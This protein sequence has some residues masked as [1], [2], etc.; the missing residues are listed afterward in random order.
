MLVETLPRVRPQE[1]ETAINTVQNMT[2]LKPSE[3]GI[4]WIKICLMEKVFFCYAN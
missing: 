2:E 1:G 3:K 4:A